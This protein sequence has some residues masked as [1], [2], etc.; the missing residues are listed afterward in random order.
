MEATGKPVVTVPG[1]TA[2]PG[3]RVL[4]G[5]AAEPV[6][7]GLGRPGGRAG[8]V[9]VVPRL[10]RAE[11]ALHVRLQ[12]LGGERHLVSH[13]RALARRVALLLRARHGGVAFADLGD[14]VAADGR[15]RRAVVSWNP[16]SWALAR[17]TSGRN[18]VCQSKIRFLTL[19]RRIADMTGVSKGSML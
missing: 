5:G 10:P 2:A 18:S 6:G 16:S 1:A 4:V 12:D 8:V 9:A 17:L 14:V 15:L 3:L 13:L 19:R 11:D 7:E